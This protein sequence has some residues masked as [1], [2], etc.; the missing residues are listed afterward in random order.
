MDQISADL[1]SASTSRG[2]FFSGLVSSGDSGKG[3]KSRLLISARKCC[4]MAKPF[5]QGDKQRWHFNAHLTSQRVRLSNSGRARSRRHRSPSSHLREASKT[6]SLECGTLRRHCSAGL[7]DEC[8]G[9]LTE[10]VTKV[11]LPL[12]R[13]E[14]TASGEEI[15]RRR[16]RQN[17]LQGERSWQTTVHRLRSPPA[18]RFPLCSDKV[19]SSESLVRSRTGTFCSAPRTKA[20]LGPIEVGA[21]GVDCCTRRSLPESHGENRAERSFQPSDS[22][23]D[24]LA[25]TFREFCI[26]A[27][28]AVS[29]EAD[30]VP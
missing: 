10:A 24:K 28:A 19:F 8:L 4:T 15:A 29:I 23:C 9:Y 16:C 26:L 11:N 3:R 22:S 2:Q 27:T 18:M 25:D 21:V 12:H 13:Y 6:S 5:L 30:R 20:A 14:S 17:S 1:S 7:A